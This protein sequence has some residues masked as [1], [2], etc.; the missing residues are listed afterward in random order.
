MAATDAPFGAI[1]PKD[2]RILSPSLTDIIRKPSNFR[3][4]LWAK[5]VLR[6]LKRQQ[7]SNFPSLEVAYGG[8]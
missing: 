3:G 4:P 2:P 6:V 1:Q 5:E 7:H 8:H